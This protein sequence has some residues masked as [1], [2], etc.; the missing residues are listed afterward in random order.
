[1]GPPTAGD[2][3]TDSATYCNRIYERTVVDREGEG[4]AIDAERDFIRTKTANAFNWL[5]LNVGKGIH[6][7]EVKADL[8]VSSTGTLGTEETPC[9]DTTVP[10][11][12]GTCAE[13]F[14]GNRTLIV[15]PAKLAN[16]A[17][18]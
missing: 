11:T 3:E 16:D 6:T 12:G 5:A 8:D 9:P 10:G 7:I 4:G 13:A 2:E 14:V 18:V 15:E 17:S 1:M